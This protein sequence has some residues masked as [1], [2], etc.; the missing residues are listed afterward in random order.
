MKLVKIRSSY[1]ETDGNG[2]SSPAFEAGNVYPVTPQS[3]FQIAIGNAELVDVP[4]EP[5]AEA[6]QPAKGAA[7]KGA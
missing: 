1:F 5:Q 6:Q 7:K 4:D 3:E 2:I